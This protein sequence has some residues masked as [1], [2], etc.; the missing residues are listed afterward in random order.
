ME[1]KDFI[2]EVIRDITD[3]V[4]ECQEEFDNGAIISPTNRSATEKIKSTN[5]D[6]KISYIDFEVAVTAIS[7]TEA[8]GTTKGGIEVSGSVLGVSLGG[9]FG[10]KTKSEENK[11]VN[12]NISKIKFSIPVVYPSK[13]VTER[14][15]KASFSVGQV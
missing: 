6:L 13:K 7:S 5:G 12:E 8:N 15:S 10:G 9:K 14:A 11:H 3:A 4:K 2:K 1:L